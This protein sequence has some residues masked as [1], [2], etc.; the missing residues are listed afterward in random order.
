M[1]AVPARTEKNAMANI[2]DFNTALTQEQAKALLHGHLDV[3]RV[4]KRLLERETSFVHR[5]FSGRAIIHR[6]TH[7]ARIGNVYGEQ[8]ESLSISLADGVWHD[9]ATGESGDLIELYRLYGGLSQP[10]HNCAIMIWQAMMKTPIHNI[11]YWC[12]VGLY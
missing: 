2:I 6:R 11:R 5:A 8:G 1:N 12:F 9:H 10:L 7:E 4:R 3:E